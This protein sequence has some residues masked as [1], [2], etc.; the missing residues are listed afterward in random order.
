MKPTARFVLTAFA[1]IIPTMILGYTWHLIFFKD[2]YDSIGIYNRTEPIIPLGFASMIVQ[3]LIVAY[4]L[5]FYVKGNYTFARA[6]KYSLLM[7]LFLFSVSTLAN[8][9]KINVSDMQTWL[10]IQIGYTVLQFG[11]VGILIGIVNKRG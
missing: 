6:I 3:G 11:I 7:G 5:P 4:L 9:A 1:Y 8:A 2:L 10:L